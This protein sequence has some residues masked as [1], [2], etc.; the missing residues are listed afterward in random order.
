MKIFNFII[1]TLLFFISLSLY[2]FMDFIL[3]KLFI[4]SC[5]SVTLG[6]IALFIFLTSILTLISLISFKEIHSL[7]LKC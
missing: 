7:K 3:Y 1:K 2:L 5:Y 4:G 6:S